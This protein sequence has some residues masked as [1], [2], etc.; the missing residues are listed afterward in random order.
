M[1]PDNALRAAVALWL[2]AGPPPPRHT[3]P[4]QEQPFETPLQPMTL[5][6]RTGTYKT[7]DEYSTPP[8]IRS[9]EV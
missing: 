9:K 1:T 7:H 2:L 4:D 3:S 8:S 6:L 5:C